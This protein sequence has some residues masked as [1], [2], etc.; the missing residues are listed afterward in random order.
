MLTDTRVR[1]AKSTQRAIKLSD[2]GGLYLLIQPHGSKLWR[3]AYRF[4]GKQKTLAFGVYPTVGLQDAREKRDA[5]KR[6]LGKGIDPPAQRRLKGKPPG[7]S[8]AHSRT[9]PTS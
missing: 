1:N 5:A 4:V 7:R 8:A 9:L 2:A 6:L 3:M